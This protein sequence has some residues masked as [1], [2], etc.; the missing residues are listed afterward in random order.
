MTHSAFGA[1]G[2]LLIA[3]VLT[4][5]GSEIIAQAVPDD[6]VITL[7]RT[8]C[9]GECPVYSVTIDAR[10]NITYDGTKFVRVQG[11]QTDRIPA[12]RVAGLLAAAERIDFFGLRDQYRTIRNPDGT[13]T[14]VT[15]LPTA[16]VTITRAGRTK[17]VENYIGAPQGLRELEQQIDAAARTAR[18]IRID[19]LTVQQMTTEGWSPSPDELAEL[20]RKALQQNEV[21][22]VKA[23]LQIGA[24]PNFGRGTYSP[25]L[26]FARSAD[27]ARALLEAGATPFVRSGSGI[28]PLWRATHYP[29][30]LIEV[31]LKAGVNPDEDVDSH[32]A[33]A[34]ALS[35]CAGN[36]GVVKLL[37]DAGADPTRRVANKSAVECA[38]QGKENAR[39][40][41]PSPFMGKPTFAQDFDAVIALLEQAVARRKPG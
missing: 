17:R 8:S 31:L 22:V 34:L 5:I 40:R 32:G 13:E 25:P 14:H 12:A 7:E 19:A 30:E 29:P 41:Q 28:T 24:D 37:L 18:W 23:L 38:R 1:R 21:D 35:A 39:T 27:A 3:V 2:S 20:L 11:R 6:F 36:A 4:A 26:M 16:F 9:F 10:G 33:T 15:D